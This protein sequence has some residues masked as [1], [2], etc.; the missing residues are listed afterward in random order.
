MLTARRI[1]IAALLA[2]CALPAFAAPRV[3]HFV[4]EGSAD[5]P[6]GRAADFLA[7]AIKKRL[8][9]QITMQVHHDGSMFGDEAAVRELRF[10]TGAMDAPEKAGGRTPDRLRNGLMTAVD[11]HRVS[12]LGRELTLFELPYVIP[13]INAAHRLIDSPLFTELTASL[14]RTGL[15]ALTVWDVGMSHFALQVAPGQPAPNPGPEALR[16]ARFGESGSPI[17]RLIVTTLNGQ[18]DVANGNTDAQQGSWWKLSRSGRLDANSYVLPTAHR[19]EGYLVLISEDFW[20]ALPAHLQD[21]LRAAISEATAA[22]RQATRNLEAR[23][24]EDFLAAAGPEHLLSVDAPDAWRAALATISEHL[25]RRV[26]LPL[27]ERVQEF[28]GATR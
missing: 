8:A 25:K 15:V 6:R 11:I 20:G 17:E 13:D 9:D 22:N 18:P 24:R 3:L 7:Q 12:R 14:P 4:H 10:D 19:Y 21:Q 2:M 27:F 26:G 5:S 28:L 23:A 1:L 16:G